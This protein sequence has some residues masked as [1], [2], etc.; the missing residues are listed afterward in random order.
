[1]RGEN[2][3]VGTHRDSRSVQENWDMVFKRRRRGKPIATYIVC[4]CGKVV[5]KGAVCGECGKR[6]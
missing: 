6:S 2:L 4:K 1:M 3:L 5:E